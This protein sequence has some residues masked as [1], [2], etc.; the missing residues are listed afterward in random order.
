MPR[1]NF[2]DSEEKREL[3]RRD[4][5]Q[6]AEFATRNCPGRMLDYFGMPSVEFLDVVAWQDSLRSVLA[7]EIDASVAGDMRI[8]A[9]NIGFDIPVD[10]V[11][12]NVFDVLGNTHRTYD[13]YNI[14][15]YGGFLNPNK[16]G[17]AK[18]V[19]A[20][21][22]IFQRQGKEGKPFALIT[23]FNVREGG[24]KT[25]YEFLGKAKKELCDR[26]NAT[27]NL[28]AHERE[29]A[30]KLKLCFSFYCWQ[31]AEAVGLDQQLVGV[32]KYRTSATMVHFHQQF[33]PR[34][35]NLPSIPSSAALAALANKSLFEMK[36]QIRKRHVAFPQ[37]S[38]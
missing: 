10:V 35:G 34:S 16:K 17:V 8:E 6:L 3:R 28:T 14:D 38:A 20:I 13:V 7:V 33:L 19:D 22:H 12:G 30:S 23:T 21:R 18:A 26:P 31:Q 36:G 11:E 4:A 37:I 27:A 15:L 32:T 29:Q 24:A 9:A 5:R 2:P 25:Y 1:N